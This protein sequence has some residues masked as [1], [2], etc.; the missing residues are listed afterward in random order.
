VADDVQPDEPM[1]DPAAMLLD[2]ARRVVPGWLREVTVDAARRG[3]VEAAQIEPHIDIVVE[4]ASAELL[5]RLD[6]LLGTDVDEQRTTPLSLLRESVRAPTQLLH[7]L[8]AIPPTSP[9]ADRFP[10]DVYR[11]G[12]ATWSDVHPSLHEPGLTWGAWKAMTVL[13]RRRDDGLR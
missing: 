13:S 5:E 4:R 1:S 8:G 11:L 2:T 10:D 3:G 6:V 9:D 7:E 12:P